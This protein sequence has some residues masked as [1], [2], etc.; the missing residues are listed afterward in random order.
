MVGLMLR[1][2]GVLTV[3][4]ILCWMF[5]KGWYW[6]WMFAKEGYW[7]LGV[8]WQAVAWLE[9]VKGSGLEICW[10]AACRMRVGERCA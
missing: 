2:V 3:W 1:W 7:G 8:G 9:G 5:V 4:G 6:E 10:L